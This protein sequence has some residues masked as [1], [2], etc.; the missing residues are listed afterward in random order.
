MGARN[1]RGD[2]ISLRLERYLMTPSNLNR[3]SF[4]ATA[5]AMAAAAGG[6]QIVAAQDKPD[7]RPNGQDFVTP[8]AVEKKDV[9]TF[10][11]MG[12]DTRP[13]D[14]EL[15]TDVLMVSRVNLTDNTVRTMSFPR[16]LYLEI[17]GVGLDKINGAFAAV[18]EN[19]HEQWMKGMTSTRATLE[20]NFG[21]TID[22]ALSV[23][24]EGVEAIVDLLGGVTIENPYDLRDDNYPTMDYGTTEIFFPAGTITVNGEEALQLMRTRHQDGDDGRVM[25]QQLVLSALLSEAQAPE[26]VAKLPELLETAS[27][28]VIT[29]IPT[30]VQ[31]QLI[32]A[33]PNIPAEN[34]YWGTITHLLWG[35]IVAGGE[36][37]YQGDWAQLPGYV[38]GFLNGTV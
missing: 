35:D 11:V 15:N 18:A 26:N 38:Q 19:G 7:E 30:D 37:V 29:N 27:E 14:Q 17:P 3:R 32:A 20:H 25:R 13:D 31:L 28:H 2:L 21:L 1:T 24:F 33:V 12:L 23:R 6:F 16:D 34:V 9:Y 5:A 10:L 4:L 8:A 22:A 36:W